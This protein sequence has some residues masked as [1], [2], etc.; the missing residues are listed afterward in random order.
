MITL[1][2]LVILI[3]GV[4]MGFKRGLILQAVHLIGFIVSFIIARLYYQKL[5]AHLSLWIPYPELTGDGAWAVFL[6]SM[7]LETAFYNGIAFVTIF[8]GAKIVLQII[9]T[10]LDFVSRLPILNIANKLGGGILGFLE[11]Y[12]ITFILLFIAAL[13]PMESVQ[14]KIMTS[15]LAMFIIEKTPFLSDLFTSMWFTDILTKLS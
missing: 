3:F 4:F 2:L 12:F 11:V 1:I 13:I 14:N 8:I 9:A 5:S 7:P 6:N 15:K 10:M